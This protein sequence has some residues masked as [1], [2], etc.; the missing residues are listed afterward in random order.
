M[1]FF[2]HL[3][4]E[5]A[6]RNSSLNPTSNFTGWKKVN[7]DNSFQQISINS[8]HAMGNQTPVEPRKIAL[9]LKET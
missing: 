9:N 4:K 6:T 5:I 8:D 3:T 2:K 1:N 7:N